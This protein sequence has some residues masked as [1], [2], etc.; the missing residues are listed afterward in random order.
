M[1]GNDGR[2]IDDLDDGQEQILGDSLDGGG[3]NDGQPAARTVD[4]NDGTG[5]VTQPAADADAANTDVLFVDDE[6]DGTADTGA[7]DDGGALGDDDVTE[8]SKDDDA[9]YSKDVRGRIDRERTLRAEAEK[10]FAAERLARE[11]ADNRA[12]GAQMFAADM[13]LENIESAIKRVEAE[14]LAAKEAGKSADEIK[15]TRELADLD[16]RKR[17]VTDTKARLKTEAEAIETGKAGKDADGKAVLNPLTVRWMDRNKWFMDKRFE[18]Q[19]EMIKAIDAKMVKD[20]YRANSEAYYIEL[21]RR[22]HRN[23]PGLRSAI[24][25]AGFGPRT[26]APAQRSGLPGGGTGALPATRLVNGRRQITLTKADRDN[27]ERFGMDPNNKKHCIEYASN[28][29]A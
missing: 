24:R 13:A 5:A 4:G 10:N 8:K 19:R 6:G 21:D 1:A 18:E 23:M 14:L 12:R 28:K 15:L 3:G 22:I 26:A 27:M 7:R 9:Q 11:E 2:N 17:T 16:S 29:V 20:G 25:K